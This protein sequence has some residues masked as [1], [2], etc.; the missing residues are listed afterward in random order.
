MVH[1]FPVE[2]LLGH[3]LLFKHSGIQNPNFEGDNK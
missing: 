3:F 1:H 2:N